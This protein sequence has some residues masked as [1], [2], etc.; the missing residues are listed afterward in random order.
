MNKSLLSNIIMF[1]TGA[2]LGS[3]VTWKIVSEREKR[4]ADEEIESVKEVY[5]RRHAADDEDRSGDVIVP[6]KYDNNTDIQEYAA[7]IA[8][9]G[10]GDVEKFEEGGTDDM[11][12]VEGPFVISPEEFD[13]LDEFDVQSLTYYADGVVTDEYGNVLDAE[14]I[15]D[16]IGA[17]FYKHY[18][19]YEYDEYSVYVR[20]ESHGCDYEILKDLR[21]YHDVFPYTVED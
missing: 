21:N 13:E 1:A 11:D 7:I 15:E 19:D 16:T 10:Y 3:L 9:Q 2:A 5:S 4:R 12:D 8:K 6:S 17:D 14:E 18:G 20:N